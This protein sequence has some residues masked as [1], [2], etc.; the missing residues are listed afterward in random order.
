MDEDWITLASY[1]TAQESCN[2]PTT[3]GRLNRAQGDT[4][5]E[6][7]AQQEP[8]CGKQDEFLRVLSH[9][10]AALRDCDEFYIH[11]SDHIGQVYV[12]HATAILDH[13]LTWNQNFIY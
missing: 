5:P 13:G 3:K 1:F 11:Q 9:A 6:M 2:L 7:A 10:A 4:Y 8:L 12:H